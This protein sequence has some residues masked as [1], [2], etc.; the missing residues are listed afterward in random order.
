MSIIPLMQPPIIYNE[1]FIPEKFRSSF[2]KLAEKLHDLESVHICQCFSGGYSESS[3]LLVYAIY[4]NSENYQ[5]FKIGQNQIIEKEACGWN[6]FIKNGPYEHLHVTH[7]KEHISDEPHSLI[8]YNY[9]GRIH[10]APPITFETLYK[11]NKNPEILLQYVFDA[12]LKL[13]S[14][15]VR[16]GTGVPQ[17]ADIL[18][19]NEEGIDKIT[20]EIKKLSGDNNAST[21]PRIKVTNEE[22]YNPLCFYPFNPAQNP[23]DAAIPIPRGIVHGDLNARNIL[24]YQTEAF[25]REGV[26]IKQMAVEVPC[27]IDYAHTGIKSLYTDIATMESVLKFQLLEID[28]VNPDVLLQ[29]EKENIISNIVPS[30][31]TPITDS[32][33]DSHLQK[34][35]SC[36][37]VL[38]ERVKEILKNNPAYPECGYWL[39][40][41]KST[42]MHVKY[43]YDS[44]SDLRKRYAFI[45]A[46][47]ILTRYFV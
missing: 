38:R 33:T 21:I 25:T 13:L 19:I 6:E 34:L 45:S 40:L 46:S 18:K 31:Q 39:T 8:V 3:P 47:L 20:G 43:D 22:L 12:V 44:H 17:I 4:K 1:I 14:D 28:S 32:Q 24:F 9:A 16:R 26:E 29:F 42:L 27:I 37:E 15:M 41:Y 23:E 36:I 5:V 10:K 30:N 2:K 35:F 7:L 11:S